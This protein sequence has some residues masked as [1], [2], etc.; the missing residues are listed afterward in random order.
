MEAISKQRPGSPENPS[1][2]LRDKAEKWG[3]QPGRR[4]SLCKGPEDVSERF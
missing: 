4:G 2:D 3:G 1:V